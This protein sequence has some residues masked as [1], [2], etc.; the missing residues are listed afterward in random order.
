MEF[1]FSRLGT[2]IEWD[3]LQED[4]LDAELGFLNSL[5]VRDQAWE[6][7]KEEVEWVR[8]G[9]HT[10]HIQTPPA[11]LRLRYLCPFEGGKAGE[12]EGRREYV[13]DMPRDGCAWESRCYSEISLGSRVLPALSLSH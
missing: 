5:L 2:G 3:K 9:L 13:V 11:G 10:C 4:R 7:A 6:E 1:L 12:W 8:Q